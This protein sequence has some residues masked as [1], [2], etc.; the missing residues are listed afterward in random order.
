M[1]IKRRTNKSIKILK[2]SLMDLTGKFS[3]AIS[4]PIDL[5]SLSKTLRQ[6]KIIGLSLL[7]LVVNV[8]S[9]PIAEQHRA[10]HMSDVALC[11]IL[12]HKHQIKEITKCWTT[13]L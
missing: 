11:D 8:V 6:A 10:N 1:K 2:A 9:C 12:H 5:K 7:S 4:L 13:I 3:S